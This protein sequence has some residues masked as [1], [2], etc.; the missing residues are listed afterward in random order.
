MG[1]MFDRTGSYQVV[2]FVSLAMIA[3]AATLF[4]ALPRYKKANDAALL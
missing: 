1:T 3:G 4:A 2:L